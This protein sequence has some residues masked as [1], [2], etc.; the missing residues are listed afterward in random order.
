MSRAPKTEVRRSRRKGFVLL[1]FA[2]I[3]I[4]ATAIVGLA[5][6]VGRLFI[7]K[8]ELQAYADTAAIFAATKLDGTR[9]GIDRA[10]TAAS[11][12][13]LGTTVP[14]KVNLAL[15]NISDVAIR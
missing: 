13:P 5:F 9:D 15:E 14:N 3:A 10:N 8:A 6:D 7:A 1:L 4:L 12:G 2:A 11:T